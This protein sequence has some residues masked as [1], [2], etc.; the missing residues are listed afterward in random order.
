MRKKSIR[1]RR[2]PVCGEA[3]I[4]HGRSASG[5][6][7]WRCASCA[8]ASTAPRADKA[9]RSQLGEFLDWLLEAAPQRKRHE[10]ARNF[11]K[12]TGWCWRLEPSIRPDGVVHHVVMAD[13]TYMN[14]W[15]LPAAID[16]ISGEV[17]AWQW[18]ERESTAAYNAE[19]KAELEARLNGPAGESQ[20]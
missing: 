5:T 12:R 16:G 17:L 14:G 3:M 13:G 9:R 2:C 6:Q 10:S 1:A 8:L 7:R 15:C 11:R 19:I 18:C 20:A 4:K